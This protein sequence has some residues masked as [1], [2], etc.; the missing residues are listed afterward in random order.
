MNKTGSIAAL[1]VVVAFLTLPAIAEEQPSP[2][3][4]PA[5]AAAA[6]PSTAASAPDTPSPKAEAESGASVTPGG[7]A[8]PAAEPAPAAATMAPAPIAAPVK[9]QHGGSVQAYFNH[10]GMVQVD[11]GTVKEVLKSDMVMLDNNRRYKMDNIRIPPYEEGPAIEGLKRAFLGRKVIIY[12]Y[13]ESLSQFDRYG[14]PL[15]H[16]LT[17]DG[18]W[19]QDYLVSNGLA[20]A[21]STETSRQTVDYLKHSEEKA[22]AANEGFWKDPAYAIKTPENVTDCIDSYQIVEGKITS[23]AMTNRG[24]FFNFGTD[25]KTDFTVRIPAGFA[26]L[27]PDEVAAPPKQRSNPMTWKGRWVRIRGWVTRNNGPLIDM[28]HL[29]QMDVISSSKAAP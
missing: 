22:R 14:L 20:W 13:H 4:P 16:I 9:L 5:A 15:V 21:Y 23:V 28:T 2:S 29:E 24:I 1:T 12:S 18:T 19:L 8:A 10:E 25:W 6:P 3:A 11:S 17:D 27:Y 26:T 7:E